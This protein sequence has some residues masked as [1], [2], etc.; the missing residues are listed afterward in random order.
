MHDKKN[1]PKATLKKCIHLVG[2]HLLC[3]CLHVQN[4]ENV[5]EGDVGAEEAGEEMEVV[6]STRYDEM[7][8]C[9]YG[10]PRYI[11][12]H[13]RVS[14]EHQVYFTPTSAGQQLIQQ[15]MITT[16]NIIVYTSNGI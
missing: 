10:F 1:N 3:V 11:P 5:E 8:V 12:Y 16:H 4:R 15:Y 7:V 6:S 2:I 9:R 13:T 14:R